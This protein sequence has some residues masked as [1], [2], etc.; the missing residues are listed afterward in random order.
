LD[1][2]LVG[3]GFEMILA[4]FWRSPSFLIFSFLSFFL[5][6]VLF[7]SPIYCLVFLDGFFDSIGFKAIRRLFG[8]PSFEWTFFSSSLSLM[9]LLKSKSSKKRNWVTLYHQLLSNWTLSRMHFKNEAAALWSPSKWSIVKSSHYLPYCFTKGRILD[10]KP[11]SNMF[12][13]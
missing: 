13:L 4:G 10:D 12:G 2:S 3:F 8:R 1:D 9:E 7:S 5:S 6:D 11:S